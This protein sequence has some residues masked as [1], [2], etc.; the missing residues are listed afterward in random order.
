MEAALGGNL[1]LAFQAV[2]NDPTTAL[3]IDRA[4]ELFTALGRLEGGFL[5]AFPDVPKT[6]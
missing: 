5:Q 1:E 6:S 4:Y 3:P 2:F